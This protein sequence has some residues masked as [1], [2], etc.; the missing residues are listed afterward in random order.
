MCYYIFI[1]LF[2]YSLLLILTCIHVY[3]CI[4]HVYCTTRI[5]VLYFCGVNIREFYIAKKKLIS[6]PT[7]NTENS[8][9]IFDLIFTSEQ[10]ST[11]LARVMPCSLSD[12]HIV[13]CL[14]N[15]KPSRPPQRFAYSRRLH[16]CDAEALNEDMKTTPWHVAE[17]FDDINDQVNF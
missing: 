1:Y 4:I 2:F 11:A 7:R 9:T 15:T 16:K 3:Y 12:H 13:S 5:I 10:P 14:I 8:R 6:T 17:V